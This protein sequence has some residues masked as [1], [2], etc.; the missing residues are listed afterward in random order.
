MTG[1]W[2]VSTGVMRRA[3]LKC[4]MEAGGEGGGG[5]KKK[6]LLLET[7]FGIDMV[8]ER[9]LLQAIKELDSRGLPAKSV[10]RSFFFFFLPPK[11]CIYVPLLEEDLFRSH[12][13]NCKDAYVLRFCPPSNK[14]SDIFPASYFRSG[15]HS[16]HLRRYRI[17]FG[18]EAAR[19]FW[20]SH[21]YR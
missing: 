14:D 21:S 1:W 9:L 8:D 18:E 17:N 6:L 15:K 10:R 20:V 12:L 4:Q 7:L 16:W 5:E 3:P 13:Q 19:Y 2:L 11:L